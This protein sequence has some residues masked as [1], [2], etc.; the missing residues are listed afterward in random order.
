MN[1]LAKFKIFIL[2]LIVMIASLTFIQSNTIHAEICGS[3]LEVDLYAGQHIN[4][5]NVTVWNNGDE[6]FV[7]FNTINNYY[8]SE[9]HLA[10]ALSVDEISQTKTGNPKVGLFPFATLNNPPVSEQIYSINLS[11]YG[12][13]EGDT[14]YIAAHA[15][16]QLLNGDGEVI[17]EETAWADGANFS[18]NNWATYA[19]FTLQTCTAIWVEAGLSV[20]NI[21]V[22]TSENI[23]YTVNFETGTSDT[24]NISFSQSISPDIGG[25]SLSTDFP[26]GW[27]TNTTTSWVVN[28]TITG[29]AIGTYELTTIATINETGESDQVTTI[30]NVISDVENPALNPLGSNPDAISISIPTDVLFT[31]LLSGS[32]LTPTEIVVEEVDEFGNPI[33]TLGGLVDDGSAGDLLSTDNVYSGTFNIISD[34]EG[35]IYFRA[36]ATFPGI[37]DPVYSEIYKLGV[38]RFPTDIQASDMSKIVTDPQTGDEIV[39]NEVLVSFMEG[40]DPDTIE[41]IINSIGGT[42]V[43][44]IYGLGYY[45]IEIP[46]TG[47]ASGVNDT[48]N[49]LLTY[50]EVL[51]AEANG[52]D[53]IF[54]VVPNDPKYSSQWALEKVRADEAWVVARGSA[55]VA[56]VD[57]GVDY[58]HEDLSGKIIKGKDVADNDNDPMDG[59]TNKSHGTHVAGIIA[60][61]VNNGKGI[62]GISWGSKILAVKIYKDSG[63]GASHTTLAAGIKYA[64][65]QGVKII[66]YSNGGSDSST[67]HDAVKYA[68]NK[69]VLFVAAAGNSGSSTKEYP[70]GY[71]EAFTVGNTTSTDSRSSSSNYGSWVNIAAPGSGIL[72]TVPDN[73]YA[74]KSGTSMATPY[75]AGAAAG[76]WSR[77]PSW[78]AVKVRERLERTTKPLPG[79]QLGAGRIDLFEAVFNGSFEIGDLSEWTKTGTASSLTSLG[80]LVPQDRNGHKNRMGYVSTGPAGD[81][82]SSTLSQDFTIQSGVSSIPVSFDYNFVTEEY[83]EWV[84]TIYDDKLII[85]LKTPS[86]NTIELA[87]E[88]INTSSFIPVSGIDFPGGDNTV[89][90]TGWK[91]VTVNVPVTE[92]PGTYKIFISD[93]GDD[94]YDSVVLIDNIRF[95]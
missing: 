48:I 2:A 56:V 57:T 24:Y 73:K 26:P 67:K 11:D 25:I 64:A 37:I 72:S 19:S 3:S 83:P 62:A 27:T 14:L 15:K 38:T 68:T 84:G 50:P 23:A 58:N 41:A 53:E 60:A 32:D 49:L 78:T 6:L 63:G 90:M 28:E 31:T 4:S 95:K 30:V 33:V 69:G 79:L 54:E 94:I 43:G 35:Q 71:A 86:G 74:N 9:T 22:G 13:Q 18:G 44:T 55:T 51:L 80:P 70:G 34:I 21:P 7:R 76:V 77:H 65:D 39:S 36:R 52:I 88:T 10:V 12:Y 75:V 1:I 42:I 47:D 20:I 29:N 91:A 85:T 46:D 66:N 8:L 45:Q 87:R 61:S 40:T 89:G 59:G 81:F 5:G 17:Q 82:V 92:G 16:V 93:A